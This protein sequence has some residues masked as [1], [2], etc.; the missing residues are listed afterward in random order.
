M[1][2][3]RGQRCEVLLPNPIVAVA[4]PSYLEKVGTPAHISELR[5]H[6]VLFVDEQANVRVPGI[7]KKLAELSADRAVR[8][9]DG[10][11]LCETIAQGSPGILFR[12]VWDVEK[13]LESGK[14]KRVFPDLSLNSETAICALFPSRENPPRRVVRF[15]EFLKSRIL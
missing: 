3:I 10:S 11:F 8:S 1:K 14:L 6:P 12:S 4:S 5:N 9:N 15:V 2:P 7:K 13:L